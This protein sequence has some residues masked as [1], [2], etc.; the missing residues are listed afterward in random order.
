MRTQLSCNN[1]TA[2]PSC[3]HIFLQILQCEVVSDFIIF[4]FIVIFYGDLYI[5]VHIL[6][7]IK[8]TMDGTAGY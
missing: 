7:H 3:V 8:A 2:L 1:R 4:Y 5:F 6:Y